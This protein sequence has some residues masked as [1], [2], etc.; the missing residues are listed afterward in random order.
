MTDRRTIK[1]VTKAHRQR[2]IALVSSAPEGFVVDIS[3]PKR[4]SEANRRFWAMVGD[5]ARAKPEGRELPVETWKS[6]LMAY[7]GFQP[8]FEPSLDGNGVVPIGYKS[9]RLNK[10][11]FSMLIE[12]CYAYGAQHGVEWSE[13]NPY[14]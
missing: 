7:A 4:S 2:A 1:L 12:A 14:T 10:A 13:P 8:R 9:S 6:L 3:A 5:I 11:D